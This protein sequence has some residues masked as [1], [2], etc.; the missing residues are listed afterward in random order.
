MYRDEKSKKMNAKLRKERAE[1]AEKER[2]A[3]EEKMER[4]K[5]SA[6]SKTAWENQKKQTIKSTRKQERNLEREKTMTKQTETD[7]K[8]ANG[9][10]A[11]EEWV[12]RKTMEKRDSSLWGSVESLTVETQP[13]Y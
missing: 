6:Q 12:R 13:F 7:I 3:N 2:Q 4:R 10:R 11:Y 5:Q 9:R 1:T 8:L